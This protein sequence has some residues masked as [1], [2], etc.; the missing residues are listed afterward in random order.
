MLI[1]TLAAGC[2]SRSEPSTNQK[3][4]QWLLSSE[5]DVLPVP[6]TVQPPDVLAISAPRVKEIDGRVATIG[7]DGAIAMNLIG[8]LSVAGKTTDQIAADL[9]RIL[10]R[11]YQQGSLDVAVRVEKYASR[12]I[13]VFGQVNQP[14]RIPWTGRDSLLKVIATTGFNDNAWIS[15][16][17]VVRPHEDPNIKQKITIDVEAMYEKGDV[18][19]NVLLEDGDLVYV[20]PTPLAQLNVTFQALLAPIRPASALAAAATGGL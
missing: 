1:L 2:A 16:V 12:F 19:R 3:V 17:A 14:G 10:K 8:S 13:Y 20:P 18:S 6:Y 9:K 11:Y 7:S 4:N 15:R 5:L